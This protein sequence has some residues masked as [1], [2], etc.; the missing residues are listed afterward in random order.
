MPTLLA[1]S[2]LTLLSGCT[3]ASGI[4]TDANP[5]PDGSLLV[6]KCDLVRTIVWFEMVNCRSETVQPTKQ[7]A[8]TN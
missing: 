6:R 7:T 1:L 5:Q 2:L 3:M 4:M 8:K